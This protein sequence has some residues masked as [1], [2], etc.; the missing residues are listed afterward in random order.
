MKNLSRLW[1]PF[2]ERCTSFQ[3]HRWASAWKNASRRLLL[4]PPSLLLL[5]LLSCC[6]HSTANFMQPNKGKKKGA[7]K[8]KT[9]YC[10]PNPPSI[11]PNFDRLRPKERSRRRREHAV[12]W[13]P[14][15]PSRLRCSLVS[16]RLLLAFFAIQVLK[17]YSSVLKLRPSNPAFYLLE[18]RSS[19]SSPQIQVLKMLVP[20]STCLLGRRMRSWDVIP[21]MY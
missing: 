10:L 8:K 21:A 16:S 19:D 4:P 17:F 14:P 13:D 18:G 3:V 7:G 11:P 6:M 9:H 2:A 15:S 1:E 12:S 5:L 20:N